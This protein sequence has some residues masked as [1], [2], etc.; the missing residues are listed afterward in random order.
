MTRDSWT[1]AFKMQMLYR[2]LCLFFNT[3][4]I[5]LPKTQKNVLI[6]NV[7][8]PFGV[9]FFLP[10]LYSEWNKLDI[11]MVVL[12]PKWYKYSKLFLHSRNTIFEFIRP[13]PNRTLMSSVSTESYCL[14][15]LICLS[16]LSKHKYRHNSQNI[17]TTA[18]L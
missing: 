3:L 18:N 1:W 16:H 2:E 5:V 11:N 13:Y 6:S 14:Q 9:L 17:E 4:P 7:K 12:I 10:L 8:K 15:K